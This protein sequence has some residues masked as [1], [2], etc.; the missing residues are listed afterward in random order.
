MVIR[1]DLPRTNAGIVRL[2][3]RESILWSQDSI[4]SLDYK[5]HSDVAQYM[6]FEVEP[7]MPL[8]LGIASGTTFGAV[9][10]ECRAYIVNSYNPSK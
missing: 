4:E 10:P 5:I 2:Y 1:A 9:R 6:G 3:E 8:D 7:E